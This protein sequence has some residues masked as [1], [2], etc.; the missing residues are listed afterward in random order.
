M[1]R[2]AGVS[3]GA[4]HPCRLL[5]SRFWKNLKSSST[6]GMAGRQ[7]ARV[8]WQPNPTVRGID[9]RDRPCTHSQNTTGDL[10]PRQNGVW[11]EQQEDPSALAPKCRPRD[12]R[13][14][15]R[16]RATAGIRIGRQLIMACGLLSSMQ[17]QPFLQFSMRCH[18]NKEFQR[19]MTRGFAR[20]ITRPPCRAV[21]GSLER[22]RGTWP[23]AASRGWVWRRPAVGRR[24]K[25]A[26][27]RARPW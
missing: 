16:C 11:R 9:P 14:G 18:P 10:V 21:V 15:V 27:D 13:H 2:L 22:R 6:S 4:G 8:V 26:A 23:K 25:L 7:V 1:A 19:P 17:A 3:G 20:R 5:A 12:R 24:A